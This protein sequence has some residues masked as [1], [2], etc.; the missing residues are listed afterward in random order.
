[1]HAWLQWESVLET[2]C[3][4]PCRMIITNRKKTIAINVIKRYSIPKYAVEN[5]WN[6][7][8]HLKFTFSY[9]VKL[10]LISNDF[11]VNASSLMIFQKELIIYVVL[12]QKSA[13]VTLKM[14]SSSICCG[15]VFFSLRTLVEFRLYVLIAFPNENKLMLLSMYFETEDKA[16]KSFSWFFISI[17]TF[18]L[19]FASVIVFQPM[20]NM[21]WKL[22]QNANCKSSQQ[23]E[24]TKK[25]LSSQF[26]LSQRYSG[27]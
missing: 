20:K 3:R 17:S 22:N 23:F 4:Q 26:L 19:C 9:E 8:G 16:N 12:D 25:I 6:N 2:L 1:M 21:K 24:K 27:G 14:S 7:Y 11:L 18:R 5:N 13:A 10:W 15:F